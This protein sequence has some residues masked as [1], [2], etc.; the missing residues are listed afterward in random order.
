MGEFLVFIGLWFLMNTVIGFTHREYF[1]SR[2]YNEET[3]AYP[4]HLAKYM[5]GR[6]FE[7]LLSH[8]HFTKEKPPSFVDQFWE[9]RDML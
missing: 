1:S 4:Y 7:L 5:S 9:V 6:C 2:E 3:F 8:L